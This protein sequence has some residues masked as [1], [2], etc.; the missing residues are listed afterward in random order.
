MTT[1][2]GDD[3]PPEL[4]DL[5]FS[6]LPTSCQNHIILTWA[7]R[8]ALDR[9][10]IPPGV[11]DVIKT[12]TTL[13]FSNYISINDDFRNIIYL[14]FSHK[15][16]HLNLSHTPIGQHR[17]LL[18][19]FADPIFQH[20][21]TLNLENTQL[22]TVYSFNLLY[23]PHQF[24]NLHTLH[25]HEVNFHDML[26]TTNFPNLKNLTIDRSLTTFNPLSTRSPPS[27]L[28][29]Q[30]EELD[31]SFDPAFINYILRHCQPIITNLTHLTFR[32]GEI[33]LPI[34]IAKGFF[35]KDIGVLRKLQYLDFTGLRTTDE[36][37]AIMGESPLLSNITTLKLV[38]DM[39]KINGFDLLTQS[40][41]LCQNLKHLTV[42]QFDD[43]NGSSTLKTI[44]S[45]LQNNNVKL[46]TLIL[47]HP[48]LTFDDIDFLFTTPA[49]TQLKTL[50]ISSLFLQPSPPSPTHRPW[51]ND[52]S[53][54]ESKSVQ[55]HWNDTLRYVMA[56][57]PNI[58]N[59]TSFALTTPAHVY[60]GT[61]L[62]YDLESLAS[63]LTSENM[64]NNLI[65][66]DLG[67][68]GF[69]VLDFNRIDDTFIQQILTNHI[70]PTDPT[71]PIKYG[72]LTKLSL[73]GCQIGF[74]GIRAICD[75]L[76]QLVEL[77]LNDIPL[78]FRQ[79][80]E[81]TGFVGVNST[82]L[83]YIINSDLSNLVHLSINTSDI[84]NDGLIELSQSQFL[85]QLKFLNLA[86]RHFDCPGPVGIHAILASP[87][88]SN[89][90]YLNLGHGIRNHLKQLDSKYFLTHCNVE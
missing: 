86:T 22:S 44:L 39:V 72:N 62:P 28:P 69:M 14:P 66:L 35:D 29:F 74:D 32:F 51:L 38:G 21:E 5:V 56:Q 27:S 33:P 55:D 48:T 61:I 30:L 68:D 23:A 75:N 31:V 9:T 41:H 43:C 49:L 80:D 58:S 25:L 10:D 34:P 88:V 63:F 82:A 7:K 8:F 18:G 47:D 36:V 6:Q 42:S 81:D 40:P 12:I 37:L 84:D 1:T 45:N 50:R 17:E 46:E 79:E 54:V 78:F 3:F 77:N 26:T 71:S 15:L 90:V 60:D 20:L 73:Q 83:S 53:S 70:S 2:N 87:L 11:C 13:D 57:S 76:T 19:I 59:L 4:I 85:D 67:D 16:A 89:L 52:L 65:E 64:P 24:L